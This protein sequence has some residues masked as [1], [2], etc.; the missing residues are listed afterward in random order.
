M[1]A[2]PTIVPAAALHAFIGALLSAAGAD[3]ASAEAVARALMAASLRGTDTHGIMLLPHYIRALQG[4][5][6]NG[7]P[8]LRF[9]QRAP[10]V[11]HLDADNGFGHL[12]GYRAIEHAIAIAR[13]QG[14]A[15]VAVSNS[16]HYGPA[17]AF[18]LAAAERGFAALSL[19]HSDSIVVPHDGTA[20]FNGT[21]PIGFAAPVPGAEPV[22]ID[23]ATSTIAWNRIPLLAARGLPLPPEV[24]V[25][26]AGKPTTSTAD[27]KR[28]MP[29]GGLG[30][31]HKGAALA[32]LV[33]ILCS[34]FTGMAPGPRLADMSGPDYSTPRHLGHWFLVLDIA[35]FVPPALYAQ[36]IGEYLADWR[37]QPGRDGK[38]VRPPGDPE[39]ATLRRRQAEGVPVE[40]TNWDELC[41]AAA[42]LGVALP[43]H[44]AG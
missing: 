40:A 21:N 34:A 30:F 8:Q 38:P 44:A 6:I 22:L 23:L 41:E 1:P 2:K 20:S 29:L 39:A 24:A 32:A 14:V 28:L 4:G 7:R 42:Q 11:G 25:D 26:A 17:G 5:R 37:A 27:A 16:S 15:S 18:A 10:A 31:G 36:R 19:T 13:T 35:A 43:A 9:E 12:A 33:E 3:A